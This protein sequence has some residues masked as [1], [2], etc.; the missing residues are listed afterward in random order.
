MPTFEYF[1]FASLLASSKSKPTVCT[2]SSR[3]QYFTTEFYE[4]T[5]TSS[6]GLPVR[7]SCLLQRIEMLIKLQQQI[8][9]HHMCTLI[10]LDESLRRVPLFTN[11]K[12]HKTKALR[13][14][15]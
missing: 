13:V 12:K 5:I 2:L 6:A 10:H 7:I 3:P 8:V 4:Q 1:N 15:K 11:L 14:R 9:Q